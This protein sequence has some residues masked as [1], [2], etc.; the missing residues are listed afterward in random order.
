M[1]GPGPLGGAG[2]DRITEAVLG[3]AGVEDAAAAVR[4]TVRVAVPPRP[5]APAAAA[6]AAPVPPDAPAA[7]LDGGPLLPGPDDPATLQ[8]ALRR[9]AEL[10]PD[11]GTV[12]IRQG[13]PDE[14]QTY[15]RLLADAQRVLGGLRGAGLLPGDA[16][17]FQFA[18]NRS[19]LTAFWACVLGGFVPT[20]VAVA[21]TYRVPND[22]NRRLGNVWRLLDRPVLLTDGATA[23]GLA[24]VRE[25]WDEPDVRILVA[26]ELLAHPQDTDWYPAD[27]D[28]PVLNLL[29]SGST[30]VP[31]CV[32][33][34]H[35]S[36]TARSLAYARSSGL[37][38]DEV[39]LL[40]MPLDHVT[41]VHCNVRDV[42][43]RCLHVN[44][45]VGHFLADPLLWLEWA[46][47]YRATNTW[48]PNFAFAMV[49]DQL[50]RQPGRSD[51]WDLS[52]LRT[53][54]NGGEPVV[55]ATSHRFL[56]L[57]AR[58]GL[59]ADA[60]VPVW[61]MAETCSG[62]TYGRQSRQDRTA[63]VV[64]ADPDS[65]GGPVR[66]LAAA[67]PRAVA[68]S[69]VGRPIPGV[70]ARIV[71]E[72]GTVLREGEIG[73]LQLRGATMMSGYHANPAANAEAFT[74]DGWF[75]TGD[76]GFVL[77]GELVIAGR[78]KDQI[79]VRGVN[80][81]AHEIESVVERV[82]G[83]RVTF[84]AAVGVREPGTGSD[85]LAVLFVPSGWEPD[86]LARTVDAIRAA[87]VREIG[88][89]LDLVVPLTEAEF[90]KTSSG[91]V[92]RSALGAKL[93]TGAL[94]RRVADGAVRGPAD[95]RPA[96]RVWTPLDGPAP[97]T[98]GG[99]LLVIAE[100]TDLAALLPGGRVVAVHQG[101][102]LSRTGPG[103]YLADT[104]DRQQL[105]SL[106]QEV[107]RRH[108]KIG[109]VVLARP[110][111]APGSPGDRLDTATAGFRALLGALADH[112]AGL[113][114]LTRGAVHAVPG[115][116]VDLGVCAV[117]ALVRTAAAE[118]PGRLV[119]Q[120]DLPADAAAWRE[121]LRAE[122]ADRSTRGVVAVR[123]G[124][125]LRPVLR[126][127]ELPEPDRAPV[128]AGGLYL[129]T[130]G[131]GGLAHDLAGYLLAGYGLRLLL[132]GRS[133]AT[134]TRAERLA[135]LRALGE[136]HY[137]QAD[138]ADAAALAAAVA[139]AE[140]QWGRPLDGVLHL[141]GED[142]TGHWERPERHTLAEESEEA[143]ARHYRAKV[144]GT[145]A[146]AELLEHRPHAAL[147]LFGSV[148]G[149]FGGA[150]FGAYAAANGF[151]AG[152]ADH[153]RHERGRAVHC[154]S[155]SMWTGIGMNRDQS[156]A[157]AA[158]R[159]FTALRPEDGLRLFLAA[160]AS[161]EHHLLLGLDL[162]HPAVRAEVDPASLHAEELVVGWTGRGVDA[163]AVERAVA[164][165]APACRIPLR[166]VELERL[167][168]RPDGTADTDA[169][170]QYALPGRRPRPFVPPRSPLEERLAALW[171]EVLARPRVGR[172]DSFFDL[173]G[174][175][176]LATR[177]LARVDEQFGARLAVHDLYEGPTVAAMAEA[178][179]RGTVS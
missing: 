31:K 58:N 109:T 71:D 163:G 7:E 9:A 74:A 154:L 170:L 97:V 35:A 168:L 11:R 86:T 75:R 28:S 80:Y 8:E 134:G 92:Q 128:T 83:V 150:Y 2:L 135:E 15:P 139:R 37:G 48:A 114:I 153:W 85:R 174:S 77:G 38:E 67:D 177:L 175:S 124:A 62:V 49:N 119:R 131:L 41:V 158:S 171:A 10:A 45:T 151:L 132:V 5:A 133:P 93:Q 87:V 12:Y 143:F 25:L 156:T 52:A 21:T 54:L 127:V 79:V 164:D 105:T 144:A 42:F 169:L 61:G 172:D 36:V 43:L 69:T 17:L 129:V 81:L 34:T 126:P 64:C 82:D 137:E 20:P 98:P 113:L 145:T 84:S 176:L 167:P 4:S 40:W 161:P 90:A 19:Y 44:A 147:L 66:P 65:L 100:E 88:P 141:A 152:F 146:V 1:T 47:R 111:S 55:A 14:L 72:A 155:W 130:G 16:A 110:L 148:N 57:L 108:G 50:D 91:K 33:H 101:D 160:V 149:E 78:R 116:R 27:G 140:E 56:D 102:S 121:A 6:A 104:R 22:T 59:P 60:M 32:R 76:L 73:E 23:P 165:A 157:P 26:D 3:V 120:A 53:V 99:V 112:P 68:M 115:D 95:V 106:I 118:Q 123:D 94:A 179:A 63:G 136:V 162:A 166:P 178:V 70:Q 173:G 89:A 46:D 122:L 51:P 30:G 13:V 159:G 96:T 24:G 18:D 138:V 103:R 107:T 39:S 117:P 142:P 29:T 125:R